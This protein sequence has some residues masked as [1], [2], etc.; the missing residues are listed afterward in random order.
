[1]RAF[2]VLLGL[3]I[4]SA[5]AFAQNQITYQGSL[6]QSGAPVTATK[7]L[8]FTLY[9]A[10]T[11][12]SAVESLGE[13][14]VDIVDGFFTVILDTLSDFRADLYLEIYVLEQG[15]TQILSPRDRIT[16][17]PRSIYSHNTRGLYVTGLGQVGVNEK[18]PSA[19]LQVNAT[20]GL[21]E[22][23]RLANVEHSTELRFTGTVPGYNIQA[24]ES[25]TNRPMNIGL[26]RAGGAVLIGDSGIRFDDGTAIRSSGAPRAAG[27]VGEASVTLEFESIPPGGFGN[28]VASI[29]GALP[30]DILIV[31]MNVSPPLFVRPKSVGTDS[32]TA[33]IEYLDLND[34]SST[35]SLAG[36]TIEFVVIR[37]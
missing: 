6:S 12:G 18:K 22:S 31:S 15:E 21:G 27:L 17:T 1:M 29:P 35:K 28:V 24:W 34:G 2:I 26:N 30:G 16:S 23:L 19:Q 4:C 11:Q 8:G 37:P 33:T 36:R 20:A 14:Q 5:F 9:N 3:V 13:H 25:E 32:A 10:L 7:T